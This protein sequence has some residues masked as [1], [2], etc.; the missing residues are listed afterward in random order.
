M[1]LQEIITLIS[2]VM[3]TTGLAWLGAFLFYDSK[4]RKAAAEARKA[5]ADSISSYAAEWKELYEKKEHRVT[6]L[7]AKIDSLYADIRALRE[8]DTKLREEKSALVIEKQALEFRKCERHGCKE[9]MPPS[10]F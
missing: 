2:S 9:R 10:N 5:E 6:E 8:T 3:G 1:E 7:E 4:K